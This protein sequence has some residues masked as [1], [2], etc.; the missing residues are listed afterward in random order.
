MLAQTTR[1]LVTYATDTT[2]KNTVITVYHRTTNYHELTPMFNLLIIA[3][4]T[5]HG[6][7]E[8]TD[9]GHEHCEC[10]EAVDDHDDD[11]TG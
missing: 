9:G 2:T 8:F 4:S 11:N 3:F 10:G 7:V 1:L 5:S 6:D